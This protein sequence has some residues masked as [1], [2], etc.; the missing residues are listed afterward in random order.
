MQEPRFLSH[1]EISYKYG[2]SN[3]FIQNL[4]ISSSISLE[5]TVAWLSEACI[6]PCL[7]LTFNSKERTE[8]LDKS[9]KNIYNSTTSEKN[10]I[11][12]PWRN[13]IHCFRMV[14]RTHNNFGL[15]LSRVPLDLSQK[16]NYNLSSLGYFT[17]LFSPINFF[18]TFIREDD[19]CNFCDNSL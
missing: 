6:S 9:A 19:I 18:K 16:P 2:I 10:R 8:F 7:Y 1:V 13:G 11:I 4:Q 15:P 17:E 14:F 12:L 3:T 5:K